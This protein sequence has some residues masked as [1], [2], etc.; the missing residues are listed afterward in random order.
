MAI[1]FFLFRL[2]LKCNSAEQWSETAGQAAH[3][4]DR[5]PSER[6]GDADGGFI[7]HRDDLYLRYV[8]IP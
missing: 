5:Q 7:H 8:F 1:F 3:R 2:I 6:T 4:T